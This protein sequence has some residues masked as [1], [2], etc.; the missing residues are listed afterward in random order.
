MSE[1]PKSTFPQSQAVNIAGL[2]QFQKGAVVSNTIAK[3][4][5]G[6]I[7][8]FAFDEDQGLSEHS[9]PFDAFVQIIEGEAKLTIGGQE[10]QARTG[11]AVMMPANIPHAVHAPVPFKMLLTMLRG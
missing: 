11:E 2:I 10:I 7:T 6:T 8:L 9:A 3:S 4:P 5:V 1:T